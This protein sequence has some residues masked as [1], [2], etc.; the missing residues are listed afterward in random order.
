MITYTV[1]GTN[2]L[3]EGVAFYDQIL[4]LM[5][6][7]RV[8][9]FDRGFAWAIAQDKAMF[10]L[11]QPYDGEDATIGNGT[12][13]AFAVLSAEVVDKMYQLALDL[14]GADEG[15]PKVGEDGRYAAYFRDLD[16]NK[17]CAVEDALLAKSHEEKDRHDDIHGGE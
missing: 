9:E 13:V 15:A 4:D 2:Y 6:A 16:G 5:G 12:M 3:N 7:K 1:L 17:L 10:S 11:M 8:L 14:G